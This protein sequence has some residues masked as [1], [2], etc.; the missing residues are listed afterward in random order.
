MGTYNNY[1]QVYVKEDI[2]NS[3]YD[4][5]TEIQP[6]YVYMRIPAEYI[7]IYHKL[8]IYFAD[9]GIDMLD[10]CTAVCKNANKNLINCFNMFN[11]AIAARQLGNLKLAN[12]LIKYIEGQLNIKYGDGSPCPEI[13]YPVD[14][15]G[16]IKAIVG[17]G[18]KPKFYVD[19]ETGKLWEEKTDKVKTVYE[20]GNN[21]VASE[22]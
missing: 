12:L 14:E 3:S 16:K 4:G 2:E 17:C 21:D 1:N 15:D 7:C 20:L 22:I 18:E 6:E 19:T 13:V 11:A 8:L 5:L 9:F 10:D